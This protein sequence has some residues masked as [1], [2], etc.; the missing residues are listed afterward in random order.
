M[1]HA[2]SQ[3]KTPFSTDEY[4][5]LLGTLVHWCAAV[6]S[7][8]REIFQ[9]RVG[10]T[11]ETLNAI[12]PTPPASRIISSLKNLNKLGLVAPDCEQIL[13]DTFEQL[14]ALLKL[15]DRFVHAGGSPFDGSRI[16]LEPLW[17]DRKHSK[18]EDNLLDPKVVTDAIG[19]LQLVMAKL[20]YAYEHG[21]QEFLRD[22]RRRALEAW[23]YQYRFPDPE[24][25]PRPKPLKTP[26]ASRKRGSL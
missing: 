8:L 4:L 20:A 6:E 14:G 10:L 16:N 9:Q 7:V 11:E 3:N 21:S 25:P 13:S 17:K 26:K 24:A 22:A 19:D 18:L 23:K 5:S 12:M 15:R 2:G 1:S